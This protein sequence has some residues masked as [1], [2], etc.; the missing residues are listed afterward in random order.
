MIT[1]L[2]IETGTNVSLQLNGL[3]PDIQVLVP[4]TPA[5]VKIHTNQ[6]IAG[7]AGSVWR[8]GAGVPDDAAGANG[9]YYLNQT[10]GDV[11]KRISGAYVLQGNIKGEDSTVPGAPGS[12]WR[13]SAGNPVDA[14]GINGDFYLNS[15][16][17][18][19]WLKAAG[20]YGLQGSIKG[21]AGDNGA[22]GSVWR[23]GSGVPSDGLGINNDFY[24]NSD[25]GDYYLKAAGTY[26]LQG[27]IKGSPGED[28]TVPGAPGS[29]WRNDAGAP[30]DGL[31]ING[32][33]YLNESNGDFYL[34][35]AGTYSLQGNIK[36]ATGA[37][38]AAGGETGQILAKSSSTDYATAWVD[39]ADDF[40][41]AARLLGSTIR[42]Q[43]F[44]FTS[45][46]HISGSVAHSLNTFKFTAVVVKTRMPAAGIAFGQ[47]V[48]GVYT[49]T[50]GYCGI[51]LYIYSGGG[52][53][54]LIA[55]TG[56]DINTWKGA[57]STYQKK[58]FLVPLT[59][60]PG[61][62]YVC[63]AYAAV[64]TTAPTLS[65]T[66][67]NG[68]FNGMDFADGAI[69][70][71]TKTSGTTLPATQTVTVA[72]GLTKQNAIQWYGIYE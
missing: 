69:L 4:S 70:S 60:E 61:I 72:G 71:G 9:D 10:N 46:I 40:I 14:I 11:Y 63:A 16:N 17:G 24:L 37:G 25:N 57:A 21:V 36:G 65:S 8:N 59:I 32:D 52:E 43:S 1:N 67:T 19:Y 68:L 31:G 47:Q 13:T 54:T 41:S 23:S 66:S 55:E 48:Q 49:A 12:V 26:S 35:A 30:S 50:A 6:G 3:K 44:G 18:E 58:P 42:A 33:Y 27:N 39:N 29:V 45:P 28:S 22:P 2:V 15:L 64:Q 38:V 53:A 20:V 56:N 62:Y 7:S 34:K 5:A 51:G